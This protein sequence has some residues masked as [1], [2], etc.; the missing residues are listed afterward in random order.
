[1]SQFDGTLRVDQSQ[2]P[3]RRRTVDANLLGLRQSGD[4]G[5]ET[6]SCCGAVESRRGGVVVGSK[7]R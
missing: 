2:P 3:E 7:S 6:V 5:N 1:M 4:G